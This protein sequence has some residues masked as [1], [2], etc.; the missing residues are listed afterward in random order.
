MDG[1]IASVFL[2]SFSRRGVRQ[3]AL[4]AAWQ[5]VYTI[6]ACIDAGAQGLVHISELF[7]TDEDQSRGFQPGDSVDVICLP[8]REAGKH[9]FSR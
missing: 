7:R 3:H 4:K 1:G 9:R 2:R 5:S 6:E 8:S